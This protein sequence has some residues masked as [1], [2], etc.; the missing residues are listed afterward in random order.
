MMI[1]FVDPQAEL[2]ELNL[3]L[4]P[5]RGEFVIVYGRRRIGKTTL[6][7]WAEQSDRPTLCWVARCET[8]EATRQSLARAL[9]RWT[10][11]QA[12]EPEPPRFESW[13][14]L[15]EQ[16]A[17]TLEHRSKHSPRA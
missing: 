16:M 2:A 5:E 8:A 15:F 3:L 10:Y 12:V 9:W 1:E 6:L 14:Q 7:H 13:E 17:R 11:P 4:R